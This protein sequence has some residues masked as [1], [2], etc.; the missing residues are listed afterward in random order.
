M[1]RVGVR[2]FKD[3]ATTY[4]ASG[5]TLVIER[6]GEPLGFFVPINAVDRVAGD[7]A[8][9][10]L[11][12]AITRVFTATGIDEDDLVAEFSAPLPPIAQAS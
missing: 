1:K 3:H 6:H 9:A 10:R 11:G 8:L 5:E 4:L 2:D 7:A 12:A